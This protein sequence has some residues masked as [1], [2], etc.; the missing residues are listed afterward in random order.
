MQKIFLSI[1]FVL[2]G[3]LNFA[4][5]SAL[6]D[7]IKRIIYFIPGQGADER[8]F[9]KIKLDSTEFR[10]IKYP[11]P[12]RKEKLPEYAKRLS[13]QIDTTKPFYLVGVSMGG[14]CAIEMSKYLHPVKTI[15]I[16]SAKGNSEIPFR[17]KFQRVIPLYKLFPGGMLKAM[18]Q[19]ARPIF[20]PDSKK[21][22]AT[23]KAMIKAKDKKFMRRSIG[24]IVKWKNKEIPKNIV[25]IHGTK[26]HT[27][28][29]RKV[30]NAVLVKKGSHMMTLTR[31]DEISVLLKAAI[32]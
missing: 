7:S 28:P 18:A 5:S 19:V 26:D 15:I 8:L 29:A 25:H 10:F 32:K 31:A 21:E 3:K 20:E 2:L 1:L 17:Y 14:M 12:N 4:Q 16:S 6:P 13:A 23:F 24:M 27:L 30:K 9:S 11:R 22:K